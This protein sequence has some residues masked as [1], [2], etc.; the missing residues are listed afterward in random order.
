MLSNVAFL[1]IHCYILFMFYILI[2]S[3]LHMH[4]CSF[5][6]LNPFLYNQ[7]SVSSKPFD[8]H[9][10]LSRQISSNPQNVF[11]MSD[12]PIHLSD[13]YVAPHVYKYGLLCKLKS[14]TKS[15][16]R[17]TF[18]IQDIDRLSQTLKNILHK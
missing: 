18:T 4:T 13:K 12:A 2:I 9:D 8:V 3:L 7:G 17:E 16:L 5:I 11:E 15:V 6:V 10:M 14:I 1:F